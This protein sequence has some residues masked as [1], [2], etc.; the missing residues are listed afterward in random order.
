ML[1]AAR[2]FAQDKCDPNPCANNATCSEIGEG[3]NKTASCNCLVGWEGA[4]C[5][6]NTDDCVDKCMNNGTCVDLVNG[7]RCE[8]L[9]GYSGDQCETVEY[10]TLQQ[11]TGQE[12]AGIP[13]RC[14]KLQIDKCIDTGLTDGNIPSRKNW[15]GKLT[16]SGYKYTL[17]LCWGEK[18]DPAETCKCDNHYTNLP[19]LGKNSLGPPTPGL[20]DS[21]SCH[22]L[23][24]ITSSKLVKSTGKPNNLD[25]GDVGGA[26][27]GRRA[28]FLVATATVLS[29]VLA[30]LRV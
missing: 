9:H 21:D 28:G 4:R 29:A 12:C 10:W 19:R 13:W 1:L 11:W 17:D 5:E 18:E 3:N 30:A 14:F 22:K 24:R 8:C 23:M 16:L 26:P 20:H 2:A 27:R 15:F 6:V 25:C 7:Y